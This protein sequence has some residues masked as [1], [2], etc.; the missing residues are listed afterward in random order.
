MKLNL[1]SF[2][3]VAGT[4]HYLIHAETVE[5]EN[6][7]VPA[8]DIAI[9]ECGL[10]LAVSSTSTAEEPKWGLYA[11]KN[12]NQFDPI[13]YGEV[14]VHTFHLLA[15]ALKEEEDEEEANPLVDVVDFF[16]QFIWVPNSSGGQFELEENGRIVTAIPGVGVLGGCKFLCRVY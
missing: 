14:A 15:N 5:A 2:L 8:A 11:G 10:Y 4:S 7:A 1:V 9:P 16:E 12:I 3:A 13:G 6:Q